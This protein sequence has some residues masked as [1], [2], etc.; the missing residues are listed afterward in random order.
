M[1]RDGRPAASFVIG[2]D[3]TPLTFD[4]LPPANTKRWVA[5]RKAEVVAA[6]QGGL[7]TLDAACT[8]YALTAE[9]FLTWRDAVSRFGVAGLRATHMQEYRD[10]VRH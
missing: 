8:R 1:G 9:E 2:P 6:V 3:G 4:D 10:A 5:R 7:I